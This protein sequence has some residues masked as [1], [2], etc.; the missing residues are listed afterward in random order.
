M[1]DYAAAKCALLHLTKSLSKRFDR[2]GV[3]VNVISSGISES[4]N[5]SQ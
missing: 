1:P 5:P 2:T 3:T 4:S